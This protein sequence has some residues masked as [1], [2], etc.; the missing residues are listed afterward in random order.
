MEKEVV[1]SLNNVFKNFTLPHEKVTTAKQAAIGL[2]RGKTSSKQQVLEGVSFEIYKGEFFGI[3]GRNGSGKSTLLKMLAGIYLPNGG[4]LT[5]KGKIS[6][7]LEL[8]VGFNP[9]LTGRENIFL[10]GAIL[11]L[12]KKEIENKYDE[13][14]D[15]SELREFMDQKLKNYSSGM[16]VRLAFSVAIHAYAP[17]I[18]LDEVLAVGD[19]KF[20]DKCTKEFFKLKQEGKTIVFV[21]HSMDL[22]QKFCDRVAL[23]EAGKLYFIGDTDEA[24]VKYNLLNAENYTKEE[25]SINDAG[26]RIVRIDIV[27]T[28]GKAKRTF[29]RGE[30]FIIEIDCEINTLKEQINLNLNLRELE[31]SCNVVGISSI[32]DEVKI[33]W[34]K[35]KNK[36]RIRFKNPNINSEKFFV[37]A[38][39]FTGSKAEKNIISFIDSRKNGVFF[40]VKSVNNLASG[41][42]TTDHQ[43]II[44]EH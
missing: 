1:I 29:Q 35:G 2:F 21:S 24:V 14:V 26:D 20:Q 3:I 8:G 13:I 32:N 37:A 4:G 28:D 33:N 7:F 18:L 34:K 44:E 9:E 27:D 22:V 5:V 39:L 6:P 43:W 38:S 11:G 25:N 23:I 41:I 16:Q 31:T 30:D 19:V 10:N 36:I 12:S 17:I 40:Q 15:F 42:L